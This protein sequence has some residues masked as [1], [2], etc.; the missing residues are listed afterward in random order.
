MPKYRANIEDPFG[1]DLLIADI[2]SLTKTFAKWENQDG[3]GTRRLWSVLGTVYELGARIEQNGAA[4]LDLIDQVSSDPNVG[5][6]PKWDPSKKG[7]HELLLVKLLSLK[8][9]TNTKSH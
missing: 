8:E 1:R 9:E 6:S 4:K 3:Q 2:V 7:A 5:A